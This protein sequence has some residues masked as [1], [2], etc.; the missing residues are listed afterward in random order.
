VKGWR[1][2]FPGI[3]S[4]LRQ[5][6]YGAPGRALCEPFLGG[7]RHR[8]ASGTTDPLKLRGALLWQAKPRRLHSRGAP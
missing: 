5:V 4:A 2:A 1:Q 3:R 7:W 8:S 6:S